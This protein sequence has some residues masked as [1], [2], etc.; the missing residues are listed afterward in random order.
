MNVRKVVLTLVVAGLLVFGLDVC[1]AVA[2]ASDNNPAPPA[3]V[4]PGQDQG[5]MPVA[6]AEA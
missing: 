2:T 4:C 3:T 1:A 6:W 5:H